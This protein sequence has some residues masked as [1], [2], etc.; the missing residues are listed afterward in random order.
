MAYLLIIIIAIILW[1]K[2]NNVKVDLLCKLT[3][4][5]QKQQK[6]NQSI[7][8]NQ[9]DIQKTFLI[10]FENQKTMVNSLQI[11]VDQKIVL[12]EA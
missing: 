9:D 2:I 12:K 1:L 7:L 4:T 11:I 3:N 5:L 8:D 6:I 10:I